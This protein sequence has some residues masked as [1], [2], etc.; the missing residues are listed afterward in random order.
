M[1][2][3][4][5]K[6]LKA[7]SD[8]AYPLNI[9]AIL[10]FLP[11]SILMMAIAIKSL[12]GELSLDYWMLNPSPEKRD[13]RIISVPLLGLAS[14]ACFGVLFYFLALGFAGAVA[15]CKKN[16]IRP[17]PDFIERFHRGFQRLSPSSSSSQSS[18][19]VTQNNLTLLA[20]EEEGVGEDNPLRASL[21]PAT[22][23]TT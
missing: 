22:K 11:L 3:R 17:V 19:N 8:M 6:V 18:I 1:Q 20:D 12:Q 10:I 21:A 13:R 16:N 23:Y 15:F 4:R 14:F 9:L 7:M 2:E 5:Q